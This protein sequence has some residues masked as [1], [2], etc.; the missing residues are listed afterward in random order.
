MH[1]QKKI[2]CRRERHEKTRGL[3]EKKKRVVEV[4]GRCEVGGLAKKMSL[5]DR[6]LEP[7]TFRDLD[8]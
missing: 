2:D 1:R 7:M 3:N 8:L 5:T 4:K 6:G